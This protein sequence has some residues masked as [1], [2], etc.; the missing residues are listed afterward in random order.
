[1][2]SAAAREERINALEGTQPTFRQSPPKRCF[3]INATLA[4]SPAAPAAVTRPAVP[5]PMTTRLYLPLG[6]GFTQS[7]GCA[8]DTSV[9]LCSSIGGTITVS[10]ISFPPLLFVQLG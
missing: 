9:R 6:S 3:S 10:V 7:D 4:P 8:C 1:M 2:T 5:P